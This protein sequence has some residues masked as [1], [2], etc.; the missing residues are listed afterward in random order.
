M[1]RAG[2]APVAV[3]LFDPDALRAAVAGHDAVVNLAT[4]IPTLTQA[5]RDERVG[6]EHAHPRRGVAQ[7]RRRRARSRRARVSCRSRSR[8]CTASTATRGSTRRPRPLA[9]SPFTEPV[10]AAEASVARFTD[11]G[12]RGVVLRFGVFQAADS[13]HM[14]SILDAARRGIFL[15]VGAPG[16]LPARDRRRRRGGGGR[17]RRGRRTGRR[18]RH[19]RR[20]A[21]HAARAWRARSP[22]GRPPARCTGR[23]ES[24]SPRAQGRAA[25]RLAARFQR[26]IPRRDRM[27]ARRTREPGRRGRA[28]RRR[29]RTSNRRSGSAPG[30]SLWAARARPGSALGIYASFL[31]RQFYDDF[32]FGRQWVS[33]D[34]PYNEHLVRDFGAMNLALAT[35]TL[36]ALYFG[37]RA[38]ARAA[39]AG[40]LVFSVPHAIYHFRHL[41]TTRRPT[42]S[43]TSSRCRSASRS[44]SRRCVLAGSRRA[45]RPTARTVVAV[46]RYLNPRMQSFGTTIFAEMSALAVATGSIN[47]GQGFPDTDGPDAVKQAAIDA[48]VAG[49]NQYPPGIGVPALRAAIAAHQQRFYGLDV[50]RRHRGARDRGRDR[51]DRGGDA[52][53]CASPATRSSRSSRTTTR[54]RRASRSRVPSGAS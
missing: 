26:P 18:L 9:D 41:G 30:S 4:K 50:R 32:P 33:H 45:P 25:R 7:P 20:R 3:S 38:A 16:R 14:R 48:I 44:R 19:R 15:D 31:P 2:A 52:R 51:S 22:G 24:A 6:G 28:D 43:A 34:G 46:N 23:R 12:G 17:A 39:A 36:V 10:R 1:R 35:V 53:A 40:W 21:D 54:T 8:S 27:A 49:H 13:H 42:R 29:A 47:L 11:A 37:S 5:A